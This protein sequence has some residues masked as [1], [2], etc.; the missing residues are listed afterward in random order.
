MVNSSIRPEGKQESKKNHGPTCSR[1]D[2]CVKPRDM[3]VAS[4]AEMG[5]GLG[6]KD[7]ECTIDDPRLSVEGIPKV[8]PSSLGQPNSEGLKRAYET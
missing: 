7:K 6:D 1:I 3:L 8:G 2:L 5:L 4:W